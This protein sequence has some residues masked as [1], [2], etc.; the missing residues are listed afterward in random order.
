MLL[1]T[2]LLDDRASTYF[3]YYFSNFISFSF[4]CFSFFHLIRVKE[5]WP[6]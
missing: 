1:L 4:L 3:S 6:T 5:I 2:F